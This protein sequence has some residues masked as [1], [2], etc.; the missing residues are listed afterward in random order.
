MCSDLL[1]LCNHYYEDA[2]VMLSAQLLT[3]SEENENSSKTDWSTSN[4][5][6]EEKSSI[7]KTCIKNIA[8]SFQ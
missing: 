1:S 8:T 4:K 7:A 3:M 2:G 5:I 6:E